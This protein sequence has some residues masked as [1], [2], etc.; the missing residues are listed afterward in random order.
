VSQLTGEKKLTTW[1]TCT[2]VQCRCINFYCSNFPPYSEG[3]RAG[4]LYRSTGIGF[5]KVVLKGQIYNLSNNKNIQ[6]VHEDS[7]FCTVDLGRTELH[8]E[9]V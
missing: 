9:L 3:A 5:K 1:N 7:K 6:P 8:T 2:H 4:P